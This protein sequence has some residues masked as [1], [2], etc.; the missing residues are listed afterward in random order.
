[1]IANQVINFTEKMIKEKN[2]EQ[3][4]VLNNI[5]HS[6]TT[7]YGVGFSSIG[8]GIIAWKNYRFNNYNIVPILPLFIILTIFVQVFFHN[9][10]YK[11]RNAILSVLNMLLALSIFGNCIGNEVYSGYL[12][13][14]LIF[15]LIQIS[16]M[17]F[18]YWFPYKKITVE[19]SENQMS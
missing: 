13:G 11:T 14:I 17:I 4:G 2:E 7:G 15:L 16:Y 12:F 18:F 5:K 6:I 8:A 3:S 1:M 10:F 9:Y 19:N